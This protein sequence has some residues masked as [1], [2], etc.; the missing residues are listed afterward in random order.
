M[1]VSFRRA[2]RT[3][4]M[5][6]ADSDIDGPTAECQRCGEIVAWGADHDCPE[7]V[8]GQLEDGQCPMC[9]QPVDRY[10]THLREECGARE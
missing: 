9:D 6:D 2:N 8:A 7:P 10:L 3:A 4:P 5:S 1:G